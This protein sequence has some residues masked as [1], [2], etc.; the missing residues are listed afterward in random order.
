M[1]Y[2]LKQEDRNMSINQDFANGC[3]C[4]TNAS[5]SAAM[6]EFIPHQTFK[7]VALKHLVTGAQTGGALSC[8]LVRVEP[9]CALAL[10]KHAANLEI[11]EVLTGSGQCLLDH[12]VTT[13]RPGTVSIIPQNINHEVSAGAEGLYILAT[14]APALL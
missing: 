7:G 9:F 11:H 8:H 6:L 3:I 2:A 1:A 5:A 13:Y 4:T 12:N 14:F 10:H